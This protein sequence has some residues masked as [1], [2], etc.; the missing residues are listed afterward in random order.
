MEPTILIHRGIGGL[1]LAVVVA[2]DGLAAQQNLILLAYLHFNLGQNF[3]HRAQLE[4]LQG[5]AGDSS[6][7]LCQAITH[8]HEDAYRVNKLANLIGH[9]GSGGGE[10]V[11]TVNTDGFLQQGIDRA[12]I[13]FILQMEHQRGLLAQEDIIHVMLTAHLQGVEHHC[14]HYPT[15]MGNL[16]LHTGIDLLPKTGHAAHHRG[17]HLLD[18]G[19]NVL[20]TEVDANLSPLGEADVGP[21][22]LKHMG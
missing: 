4:V 10:E 21:A 6:T 16:L 11:A 20:R 9:G 5:E 12:L 3:A 14:L 7:A 1:L 13:E 19:L 8:H 17:T 22:S 15:F 2:H 18:G